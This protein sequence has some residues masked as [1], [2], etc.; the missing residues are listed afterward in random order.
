MFRLLFVS[1]YAV[2]AGVRIFYRSQTLGRESEKV[3]SLFNKAT[4]A[5]MIAILGYFLSLGLWFFIPQIIIQFYVPLPSL[6]RW[7]GGGLATV[8]IALT[9][10]IHHTL[11][12]QYAARWEIQKDH[13]L[14]TAGP[15]SRVRHPMYTTFNIFGISVALITAN[16]LAIFFAIAIAIPFFWIARSEEEILLEQ[17]GDEYLEYMKRTGR[18]LP[19]FGYILTLRG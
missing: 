17:F 15:Y 3:Y 4:I 14:I 7:L 5:L 18:F 11:G 6:V 2:F 8:G 12:K 16:L 13:Q 19:R 9:V 1:V 10:W